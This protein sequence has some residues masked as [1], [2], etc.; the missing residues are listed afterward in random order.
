MSTDVKFS[1]REML[2]EYFFIEL[3]TVDFCWK[4]QYE[5]LCSSISFD[6]T[7]Q[8][9]SQATQRKKYITL[10]PESKYAAKKLSKLTLIFIL[11]LSIE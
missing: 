8:S 11:K 1:S 2:I 4:L 7:I 6:L 10:K 3:I 5:F 9:F